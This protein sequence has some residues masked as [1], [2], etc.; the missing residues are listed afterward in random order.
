MWERHDPK[1]IIQLVNDQCARWEGRKRTSHE[2]PKGDIYRPVLLLSGQVGTIERAVAKRLSAELHMDL[3]AEEIVHAIAKEARL[4]DRIIRTMDERGLTYAK[5]I[6]NRLEGKNGMSPEAYFRHLVRVIVAIGRHGNSIVLGHGA[7]Y[8]LRAP[9]NLHVRFIAPLHVR[10]GCVSEELGISAEEADRRI[11]ILDQERRDFVRQYFD[12]DI[13]D[14]RHF[15]LVI[16]NE[17]IDTDLAVRLIH[18]AFIG[19][20][21]KWTNRRSRQ[22]HGATKDEDEC[23]DSASRRFGEQ[24]E[25]KRPAH[26]STVIQT[27]EET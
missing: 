7:A 6:L 25:E 14:L 18:D 13:D 16:N 3:F 21:W 27:G 19:R 10:V 22:K 11:K 24:V 26:T 15:D 2:L 23:C 17:F 8:I 12:R 5:E 4:S 20:N 1:S 9:M